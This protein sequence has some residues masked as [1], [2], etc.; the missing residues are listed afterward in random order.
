MCIRDRFHYFEMS[1]ASVLQQESSVLAGTPFLT[2][3]WGKAWGIQTHED[4]YEVFYNIHTARG[5]SFQP[6][7]Q[8][9]N[10]PGGTTTYHDAAVMGLQFNCIL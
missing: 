8:Y 7:F 10:R 3:Q 1:R 5:M 9:I 6:D 2:N 4:V